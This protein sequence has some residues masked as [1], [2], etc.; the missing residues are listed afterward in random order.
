M[1]LLSQL[2]C[3][4]PKTEQA[5]KQPA[6]RGE[7]IFQPQKNQP[8][9]GGR[10]V[11]R[12]TTPGGGVLEVLLGVF[13]RPPT[14]LVKSQRRAW[15]LECARVGGAQAIIARGALLFIIYCRLNRAGI[16]WGMW[17]PLAAL[18]TSQSPLQSVS[19]QARTYQESAA[20]GRVACFWRAC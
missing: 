14:G 8:R 7:R 10:C 5:K 13:L 17:L 18:A 3:E 2:L 9:G 16:I 4:S 1:S 20:R 11:D 6:A 15:L 12:S 19:Q